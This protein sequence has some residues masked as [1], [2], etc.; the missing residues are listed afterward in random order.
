[1][2]STVFF[3]HKDFKMHWMGYVKPCINKV[4]Y[5]IHLAIKFTSTCAWR[6][7][8]CPS[9]CH[10]T[11]SLQIAA[12]KSLCKNQLHLYSLLPSIPDQLLYFYFFLLAV[13]PLVGE[14][15]N[16]IQLGQ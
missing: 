13:L 11:N 9:L 2:A 7:F 3:S 6:L 4:T 16:Y 10:S 15:Y 12:V 5:V 1:M 14:K 8:F